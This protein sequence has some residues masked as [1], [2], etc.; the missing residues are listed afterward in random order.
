MKHEK[1][2]LTI[3][4]VAKRLN[5]GAKIVWKLIKENLIPVVHFGYRTLRIPSDQLEAALVAI[6][7]DSKQRK[8]RA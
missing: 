5:V 7:T 4:E 1:E 3:K 8:G 6:T 2:Y